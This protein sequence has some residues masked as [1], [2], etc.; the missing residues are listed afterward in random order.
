MFRKGGN[1]IA[2]EVGNRHRVNTSWDDGT[3]LVEEY[4]LKTRE[5]LLR[6]RRKPRPFGGLGDWEYLQGN[7]AP[8]Y[9]PPQVLIA[10][11]STNVRSCSQLPQSTFA[12]VAIVLLMLHRMSMTGT[13]RQ[14]SS[15]ASDLWSGGLRHSVHF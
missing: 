2:T 12:I 11:S 3:E 15:K 1:S 14:Q 13:E 8:G 4:D 7:E 9:R 6:K 10:E 5:L